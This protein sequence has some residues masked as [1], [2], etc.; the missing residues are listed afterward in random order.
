MRIENLFKI[1]YEKIDF[2]KRNLE[3]F[4]NM[5]EERKEYYCNYLYRTAGTL[6]EV[7]SAYAR[8]IDFDKY[9]FKPTHE[10]V[11]KYT[12]YEDGYHTSFSA[13]LTNLYGDNK[14]QEGQHY[15]F[16]VTPI[17]MIHVGDHYYPV[18]DDDAGQCLY[19][20]TSSGRAFTSSA[21]SYDPIQELICDLYE[22]IVE[23]EMP[24]FFNIKGE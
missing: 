24:E 13:A 19:I 14:A 6:A 2:V 3:R 11:E 5:T 8:E 22:Y 7:T 4:P 23:E 17:S 16:K 18:Y 10:Q 15:H 9:T 1:L 20:R 21:W 12:Y